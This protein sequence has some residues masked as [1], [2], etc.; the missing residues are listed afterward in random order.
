MSGYGYGSA[1]E[2]GRGAGLPGI[3]RW[4]AGQGMLNSCA[5]LKKILPELDRFNPEF[6]ILQA[7]CDGLADDPQSGLM[8]KYCYCGR[9]PDFRNE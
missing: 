3:S 5:V 4:N 9:R 2:P 6:I 1:G 8:F 7:G